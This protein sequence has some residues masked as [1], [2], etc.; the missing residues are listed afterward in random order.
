MQREVAHSNEPSLWRLTTHSTPLKSYALNPIVL[1]AEQSRVIKCGRPA[2]RLQQDV[3]HLD[4]LEWVANVTSDSDSRM[5][6]ALLCFGWFLRLPT[7]RTSQMKT[8]RKTE[9]LTGSVAWT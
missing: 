5:Q 4:C 8:P 1:R 6:S 3:I 2:L 9:R 7:V